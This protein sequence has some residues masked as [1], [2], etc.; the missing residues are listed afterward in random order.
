MAQLALSRIGGSTISDNS[1]NL[2]LDSDSA[3]ITFAAD[4]TPSATG[5]ATLDMAATVAWDVATST[6]LRSLR[7]TL[8]TGYN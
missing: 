2:T 3:A 4:D 5:L 1:G 7:S 6:L 8:S